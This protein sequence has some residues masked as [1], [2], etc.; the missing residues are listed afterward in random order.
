LLHRRHEKHAHWEDLGEQLDDK[1]VTLSNLEKNPR[2]SRPSPSGGG[3]GK[4]MGNIGD[5]I[6]QMMD[7]DPEM[8]RR[9]NI[10]RL[11]DV[12]GQVC[13]LNMRSTYVCL[14]A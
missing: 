4:I 7:S 8:T 5:K 12:I 3:I 11:K 10:A 1:R 9:S 13:I 6:Q 14:I 2:S